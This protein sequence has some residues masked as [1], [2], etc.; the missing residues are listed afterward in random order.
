MNSVVCVLQLLVTIRCSFTS[1]STFNRCC[2][3]KLLATV[4]LVCSCVKMIYI[5]HIGDDVHKTGCGC[6]KFIMLRTVI[7]IF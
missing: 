4:G 6:G 1:C 3:C 5:L 2:L 7:E